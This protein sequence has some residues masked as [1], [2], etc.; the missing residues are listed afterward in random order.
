MT[1]VEDLNGVA[2]DSIPGGDVTGIPSPWG[3]L[4]GLAAPLLRGTSVA[5]AS[6]GLGGEVVRIVL[7]R[8][9]VEAARGDWRFKDPTWTS[10]PIYKRVAQTYLAACAAVDGVLDDMETEGHRGR[11]ERSRFAMGILTSALAPTNTLVGNPAALKKTLEAGGANLV[12]GAGNF[13]HDVRRNGGMPSM[14]K[15]GALKVGEDLALTPGQVVDR[16]EVAE[17]I[18]YS[19]A[20][21][22]VRERPMLVVPPPIGKFYFL[23]LRPGRSFV[24]HSVGSGLQTFLLSWRNPGPDQSEWDMDTYAERILSA[25]DAVREVTGSD[26]VNVIGFCAGGILNTAVLNHLASRGDQRI[27]SASYAVTLLDFGQSSPIGAFS[28]A[29]LLSL[30]RWK[31]S[32]AGVISAR[33]MGNVFTWMRPNDLVW[34]Y[35]VN[36]YL[37]GQDPPVFDILSWNADGTNLPSALHRQFLDIFEH[38]PLPDPGAFTVLGTPVELGQITVPNYVTGAVSDHLTPWKS[39]YLTTQLLGGDSTFALSSAGHIASLVNP[40]GNPKSSYYTAPLDDREAPAEWLA[41]ADK[42]TGSWWEHW[43]EWAVGQSGREV[44]ASD[45]LG[46]SEHPLLGA[47]PGSYVLQPS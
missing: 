24:E 22:R 16:D 5:R 4:G 31:S 45:E 29:R 15:A 35:W 12:S 28:S 23:D 41:R 26:D 30:A 34:N 27:H 2:P 47:A 21:E 43:A 19:P 38:N 37:M 44:P 3:L 40:P 6:V 39:C 36:N 10:N 20:T 42:H 32:R 25:I 14:A 7:G 33:S 46:S 13:A 18:Q 11:T 8:S 1:A 17:L 9:E